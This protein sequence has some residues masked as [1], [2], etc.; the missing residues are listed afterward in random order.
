MCAGKLA[1]IAGRD[2]LA[3]EAL[4]KRVERRDLFL[5]LRQKLAVEHEFLLFDRE[6]RLD[7]IRKRV[8]DIVAGARIER[9]L[10]AQRARA[11]RA[12]H[13]TWARLEIH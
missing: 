10:F 1:S 2:F 11:A 9:D 3:I 7:D 8:A 13:P 4:L 12:R 5:I 6:R